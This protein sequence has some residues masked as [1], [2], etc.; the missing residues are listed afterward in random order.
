MTSA[1]HSKLQKLGSAFSREI[2]QRC[3][4]IPDLLRR[5]LWY[6]SSP[7]EVYEEEFSEVWEAL[8]PRLRQQPAKSLARSSGSTQRPKTKSPKIPGHRH[9]TRTSESMSGH[10]E[11]LSRNV[12]S[13]ASKGKPLGKAPALSTRFPV[14]LLQ[15]LHGDAF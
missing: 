4:E 8:Y 7:V 10:L 1:I 2:Y 12:V 6:E 13:Q 3:V 5:A 14:H 9:G 15:S 11:I